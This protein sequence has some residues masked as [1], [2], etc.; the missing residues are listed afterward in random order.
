M[1]KTVDIAK[2]IFSFQADALH[3]VQLIVKVSVVVIAA[4]TVVASLLHLHVLCLG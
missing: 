1:W 3:D 4:V 2:D